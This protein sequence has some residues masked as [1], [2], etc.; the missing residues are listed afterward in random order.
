MIYVQEK[1]AITHD[2]PL[3]SELSKAL[4]KENGWRR[5]ED[6]VVVVFVREQWNSI[7]VQD[8]HE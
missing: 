7:G 4:T 6:T 5:S 2:D 3:A 1:V 8:E